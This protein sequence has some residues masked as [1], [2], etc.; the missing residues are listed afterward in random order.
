VIRAELHND[1]CDGCG[2]SL[3]NAEY[4]GRE[5]V[6]FARGEYVGECGVVILAEC[7]CGLTAVIALSV[8]PRR[9]A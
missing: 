7:S 1:Q 5:R 9:A 6:I 3:H 8:S 4:I 2:S